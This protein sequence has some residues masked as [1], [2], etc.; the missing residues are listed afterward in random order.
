MED[1][2]TVQ[3]FGENTLMVEER[4]INDENHEKAG[5]ERSKTA[6]ITFNHQ[7]NESQFKTLD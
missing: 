5:Q 3:S 1:S 2:K 7:A 6:E 4:K